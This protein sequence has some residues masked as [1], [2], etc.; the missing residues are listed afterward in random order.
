MAEHVYGTVCIVQPVDRSLHPCHLF[1]FSRAS[2]HTCSLWRV[3]F[4]SCRWH[5]NRYG[6]LIH[7]HWQ[8]KPKYWRKACPNTT[9]STL[10]PI[11]TLLRLNPGLRT[12]LLH[13]LPE[14]GPRLGDELG[15]LHTDSLSLKCAPESWRIALCLLH[16]L[17]DRGPRLWDELGGLH[18][19]S[20]SLKC[21]PESWRIA[22]CLFIAC[23][24]LLSV[25]LI[26]GPSVQE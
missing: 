12:C 7:W 5:S 21:A 16:G 22:L 23:V 19:D 17:P 10:N 11:Q 15:G 18:T 6:Q 26:I 25:P 3:H 24:M 4:S 14:R 20:L 9:S 2:L 13:G 1:V 8:V